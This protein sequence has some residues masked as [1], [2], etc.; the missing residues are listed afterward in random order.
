MQHHTNRHIN[1]DRSK[2][3]YYT[4]FICKG[5]HIVWDFEG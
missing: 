1:E 2:T 4:L 3:T 5:N